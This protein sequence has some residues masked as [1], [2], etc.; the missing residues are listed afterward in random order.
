[1]NEGN[2]AS[3]IVNDLFVYSK[4][5]QNLLFYCPCNV[6]FERQIPVAKNKSEHQ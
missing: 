4:Y 5:L 1:M 2:F 6:L 3:K